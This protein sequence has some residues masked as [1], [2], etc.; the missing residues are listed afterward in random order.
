GRTDRHLA[1]PWIGVKRACRERCQGSG[2]GDAA[3][4]TQR[5]REEGLGV[6][7]AFPQSREAPVR[8]SGVTRVAGLSLSA[9]LPPFPPASRFSIGPPRGR[10]ACSRVAC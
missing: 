5:Q 2:Y 4:D 8:P 7:R 3:C 6:K 1:T 10:I 9:H